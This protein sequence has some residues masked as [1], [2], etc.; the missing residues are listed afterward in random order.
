MMYVYAQK[1][2]K[3]VTQLLHRRRN[4]LC[5]FEVEKERERERDY[6]KLS[7]NR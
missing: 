2:K 4:Y 1:V 6:R 5:S 3:E 7:Y